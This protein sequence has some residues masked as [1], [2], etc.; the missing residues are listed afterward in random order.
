MKKLFTFAVIVLSITAVFGVWFQYSLLAVDSRDDTRTTIKIAEG[1]SVDQIAALLSERGLIRSPSAFKVFTKL[2][3]AE[4]SLQAGSFVMSPSFSAAEVVSILQS[5]RAEEM[6]I[7]IPEGFTVTDIDALLAEKY[8]TQ[9]DDFLLC[10]QNCDLSE[11]DFLPSRSGL[12]ERGGQV[13][14]Y[15]YPDTY[16]VEATDFSVEKFLKRLLSTFESKII[17]G[18]S[19]Y[20]DESGRD[21]HEIVTMASLIEE[22]VS[23]GGDG[24]RA[25]V[26]GIL[27]SRY[28]HSLGLGVD[29]TV[30]YILNKPTGTITLAD[31]NT[32]DPYN[33]RKFR[34]LPPGPIANAGYESILATVNPQDS[35]Y[36]YYLHDKDGGVHYAVTNEEH[37]MNRYKY[38]K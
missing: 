9:P 4:A 7:T 16:F 31:L 10:A 6:I 22:E 11:Y 30:R 36:M 26:S 28:D 33:T 34:D 25:M 3:G 24:E 18:L 37:N 21:L 17:E 15:L 32:N 8:L 1:S 29:A 19:E 2:N 23:G 12:A 27:W 35:E 5:G 14:G 20:I 13:E 38:L